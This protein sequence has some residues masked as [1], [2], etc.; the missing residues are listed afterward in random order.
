M[1]PASTPLP[2]SP[3][4]L[5]RRDSFMRTNSNLGKSEST[6]IPD[7]EL[8]SSAKVDE[9]AA[10]PADSTVAPPSAASTTVTEDVKGDVVKEAD[11]TAELKQDEK[12]ETEVTPSK[13]E[14]VKDDPPSIA[15]DP[16]S[17][18]AS[19]EAPATQEASLPSTSPSP[20]PTSDPEPMTEPHSDTPPTLPS[21][22]IPP[23]DAPAPDV[24]SAATPDATLEKADSDSKETPE[25]SSTETE[26]SQKTHS[27]TEDMIE[28]AEKAAPVQ[29]DGPPEP[30]SQSKITPPQDEHAKP[31]ATGVGIE[32]L[33]Q[34]L[35]QVEQRFTGMSSLPA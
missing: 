19:Q 4:L 13:D 3:A 14:V 33:Q 21:E 30:D 31:K 2:E 9:V 27:P 10:A 34:R 35:K 8:D 20:P 5:A 25:V 11:E 6:S 26:S 32:E 24:A 12:G 29:K 22:A 15:S 28:D 18:T 16:Q 17:I 23:S 1:S 7:L